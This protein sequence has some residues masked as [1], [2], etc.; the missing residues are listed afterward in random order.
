MI[1]FLRSTSIQIQMNIEVNNADEIWD[2]Y[3]K[4]RNL[5]GKKHRRGDLMKDNEFHMVVHVC[6][7]NCN[8]ELLIQR[9]QPWKKGWPNMWDITVGGSAVAGETSSQAA[10]RE[11]YEE[12]GYKIDLSE[13][14]PYFTSN[15]D[16][17]FDDFYLVEKEIDL[18]QLNLQYEEVQ[19]VKWATKEE[20]LKMV[21]DGE[22]VDYYFIEL[23]F[24]MRKQRG[25]IREIIY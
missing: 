16:N 24:E 21:Q 6:I 3:D 20:I 8:N 25:A 19:A 23:L 22:F 5:T 11:T 10:E 18:N 7:F 15:F 2:L 12:I 13:E 4:D 9:R 1:D 17:G 14:R